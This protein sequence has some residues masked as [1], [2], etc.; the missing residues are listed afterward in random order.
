MHLY[1]EWRGNKAGWYLFPLLL[2]SS[3]PSSFPFLFPFFSVDILIWTLFQYPRWPIEIWLITCHSVRWIIWFSLLP[4]AM[5]WT[6]LSEPLNDNTAVD[7]RCMGW[8][9]DVI[10]D[11]IGG[12]C[13]RRIELYLAS[14]SLSVPF[15]SSFVSACAVLF[16]CLVSLG[17]L[18]IDRL[19][20][21]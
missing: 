5:R 17:R 18:G 19:L 15:F 8:L 10:D 16:S 7:G 3:P 9:I 1:L 11:L 4:C 13:C 12:A 21:R 2:P 14:V 20:G 6:N